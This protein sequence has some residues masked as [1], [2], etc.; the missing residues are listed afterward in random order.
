MIFLVKLVSK[1]HS[2]FDGIGGRGGAHT[3]G[4]R[5]DSDRTRVDLLLHVR[6]EDKN[7]KMLSAIH[8]TTAIRFRG[9]GKQQKM[10]GGKKCSRTMCLQSEATL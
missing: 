9:G 8:S 3:G 10:C 1:A 2:K 7:T 6:Q 5:S 4:G